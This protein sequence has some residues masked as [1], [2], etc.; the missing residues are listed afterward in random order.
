M[1]SANYLQYEY[2]TTGEEEDEQHTS[3]YTPTN[4]TISSI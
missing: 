3:T 2:L 4:H 1:N